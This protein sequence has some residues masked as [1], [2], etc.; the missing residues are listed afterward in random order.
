MILLVCLL[1][2]VLRSPRPWQNKK[3]CNFLS[4][5]ITCAESW[6]QAVCTFVQHH[7]SSSSASCQV[8][9]LLLSLLVDLFLFWCRAW[10]LSAKLG[11]HMLRK[12]YWVHPL[13]IA[14]NSRSAFWHRFDVHWYNLFNFCWHTQFS[15]QFW[16]CLTSETW[17]WVY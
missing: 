11:D 8:V 6:A 12:P 17:W 4:H 14:E 3:V 10:C 15:T 16:H 13:P 2:R 1:V 5:F 9:H 7:S